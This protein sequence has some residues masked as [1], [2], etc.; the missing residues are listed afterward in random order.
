MRAKACG[1]VPSCRSLTFVR[2]LLLVSCCTLT[3]RANCPGNTCAC[4]N[5]CEDSAGWHRAGRP[6]R[7]CNWVGNRLDNGRAAASQCIADAWLGADGRTAAVGC[8]CSC[9]NCVAPVQE[10][11]SEG[12]AQ[13]EAQEEEAQEEEAQ[14]EEA[15]EEHAQ[16]EVGYISIGDGYCADWIYPPEG[17]YPEFLPSS[18]PRYDPDRLQE[19]A[20]RCLDYA[21]TAN[22]YD[23]QAFYVNAGRGC[24]WSR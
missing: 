7:G 15:Q 9:N 16:E 1:Q 13:E 2:G 20:N 4:G 23:T 6:N 24:G 14:E 5:D 18:D 11:E 8:P 10:V 17:A 3:A 19:C 22:G 21:S 12:E